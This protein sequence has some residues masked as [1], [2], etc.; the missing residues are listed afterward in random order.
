MEHKTGTKRKAPVKTGVG[1]YG[2]DD[3]DVV[4][5]DEIIKR[6][7]PFSILS[8]KGAREGEY[9]EFHSLIIR[10]DGFEPEVWN[11]GAKSVLDI[12][13]WYDTPIDVLEVYY[14]PIGG[15]YN[16]LHLRLDADQKV[17]EKVDE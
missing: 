16:K 17:K 10:Q 9:G 5:T 7:K 2:A 8:D 15:K 1:A 13:Q 4:R 3:Y 11:T 6:G 14:I 12:L